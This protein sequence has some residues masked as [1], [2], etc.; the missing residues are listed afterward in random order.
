M[1]VSPHQNSNTNIKIQN[2]FLKKFEGFDAAIPFEKIQTEHYQPALKEAIKIASLNIS[3][4]K[5]ASTP[6]TFQNTIE[7]LE[8]STEDMQAVCSVFFN[9]LNSDMSDQLQALAPQISTLKASFQSDVLLDE[10]LFHKVEKVYKESLQQLDTEQKRL[11]ENTYKSFVRNGAL[12]TPDHKKKIR[13]IDQKLATL[14]PQFSERNLKAMEAFEL[15]IK[16]QNIVKGLPNSTIYSASEKAKQ[17]KVSGYLFG[18]EMP[19]YIPFMTY[20]THRNLREKMWRAYSSRCV[21]GAF[22]TSDIINQIVQLKYKRAKLLGYQNH[23]DYV[24]E[25]RMAKSVDQVNAFLQQ[26]IDASFPAAQ[27]DLERLKKLFLKD[28]PG[29]NIKAWDILY[30][31]EKLKAQQF[32]FHQEEL[33]PYF[34]LDQVL[35]GAFDLAGRLYNL[36]FKKRND[37]S[38]YH[39]EVEVYEVIEKTTREY[40]ALFYTDF[41]PRSTKRTGAW[42]TTFREQ[43]LHQGQ[44]KRPHVSI[45]CNFTRPTADQPSL[46]TFEESETLFHEFGHA[47]HAILSDCRYVSLASPNVYWDF[48]E[49]PSQFM[50]NWLMEK[51]VLDAFAQHYQNKQFIPEDLFQKIKASRQYMAGYR[52]LR[53]INF[54]ILDMAWHAQNPGDVKDIEAF[55]RKYTQKTTLLPPEAGTSISHAFAHIFGGGY[56][57]G[58]YSYKWAEVLDADAFEHFKSNGLFNK[59]IA[60]SFCNNILAKGDT[61][62][63]MILYER[64]RGQKPNIQALLRRDGLISSSA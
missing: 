21:G 40:K 61:E 60:N 28:H 5:E 38:K 44:V 20:C 52:S 27:K 6:P 30:Y 23:A 33:R 15:H 19:S 36:D 51:P 54:A 41:F 2:P 18:L 10:K 37:I 48:V 1:Q 49:L 45:V 4:I 9:L 50:Q 7:A 62:D 47:L 13:E 59:D 26:L 55:E 22:D 35:Q 46:L 25:E 12:L 11:T 34:P 53:Q 8:T 16:D 56:S 64:F 17:K 24:L 43:G 29:Q 57:A 3:K 42:M 32:A 63:P 31:Q 14:F 39:P 58:Y